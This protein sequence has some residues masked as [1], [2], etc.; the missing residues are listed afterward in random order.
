[1]TPAKGARTTSISR[2]SKTFKKKSTSSEKVDENED[3]TPVKD[4]K[5][6]TS[7][8]Q[9]GVVLRKKVNDGINKSKRLAANR[10]RLLKE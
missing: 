4:A 6:P 10:V 8:A 1:M 5:P 9:R 7:N 3:V 2:F